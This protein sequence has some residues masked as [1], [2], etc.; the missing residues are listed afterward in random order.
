MLSKYMRA[1]T[2]RLSEVKGDSRPLTLAFCTRTPVER[3]R[4][5]ILVLV[6]M[7]LFKMANKRRKHGPISHE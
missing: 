6:D 7:V 2:C 1:Y 3:L 5:A 4:V